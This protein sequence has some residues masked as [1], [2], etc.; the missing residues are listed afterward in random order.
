MGYECDV[1]GTV[2]DTLTRKRVH[3]C[4]GIPVADEHT[5]S[6]ELP[7][8]V[9]ALP[10]TSATLPDGYMTMEQATAFDDDP[11]LRRF[12]PILAIGDPDQIAHW[13]VVIGYADTGDKHILIGFDAEHDEWVAIEENE[14][15]A[16]FT[17]D[18][19]EL[20]Y[21]VVDQNPVEPIEIVGYESSSPDYPEF[22]AN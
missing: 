14:T 10:D 13:D 4:D 3:D 9:S 15:A 16:A 11:S 1:C 8:A 6:S 21:W 22:N 5:I 7:R 18:E 17:H 20:A 2:F 19:N 12:F